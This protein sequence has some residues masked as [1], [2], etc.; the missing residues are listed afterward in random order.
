MLALEHNLRLA[1]K[2]HSPEFGDAFEDLPALLINR[3]EFLLGLTL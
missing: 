2:C 3:Q 1:Q